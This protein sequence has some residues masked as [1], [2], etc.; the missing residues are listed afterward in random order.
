MCVIHLYDMSACVCNLLWK[1]MFLLGFVGNLSFEQ[2]FPLMSILEKNCFLVEESVYVCMCVY[3][4][5]K[6]K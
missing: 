6:R 2:M 1:R 4:C 5:M 3:V